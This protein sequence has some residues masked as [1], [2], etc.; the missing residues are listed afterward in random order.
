[1]V[2]NLAI[3]FG[4]AYIVLFYDF[5]NIEFPNN[6]DIP[7][8][9]DSHGH[10]FWGTPAYSRMQEYDENGNFIKGRTI[11]SSSSGIYY[12][13]FDEYDYIQMFSVRDKMFKEIDR[14]ET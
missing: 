10:I 12:Y 9:I 11:R 7:P 14:K 6:K 13:G 8:I 1:M 5:G 3:F 4:L 2:F